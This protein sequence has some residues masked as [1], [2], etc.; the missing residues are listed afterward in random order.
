MTPTAENDSGTTKVIG[1]EAT[2]L[3]DMLVGEVSLGKSTLEAG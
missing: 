3:T 1:F 2:D